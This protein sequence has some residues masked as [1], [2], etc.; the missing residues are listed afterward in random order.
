MSDTFPDLLTHF[1]QFLT[2]FEQLKR[3]AGEPKRLA[4]FYSESS[5]I[6]D[7]AEKVEE[8]AG[9]L[10]YN[11]EWFGSKRLGPVSSRFEQ[12]WEEYREQWEPAIRYGSMCSDVPDEAAE[13]RKLRPYDKYLAA[14][15]KRESAKH[16][17]PDPK[18]DEFFDPVRHD[19]ALALSLGIDH[20]RGEIHRAKVVANKCQIALDAFD[21]LRDII[22]IDIADIFRRWREAPRFLV[23]AAVHTK[24]GIEKAP[25]ND[26]LDDAIRAYVC[27][28]SLAAIAMCRAVL[29]RVVKEHYITDPT[30][31]TWTDKSGKQREKGLSELIVLAEKRFEYLGTLKLDE[32]KNAADGIL[33]RYHGRQPLSVSDENAIIDYMQK[34]KTLIQKVEG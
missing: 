25:L 2:L 29:E 3:V 8:T 27:G 30:E 21:H 1:E 19:G 33:H 28:A 16:E 4:E 9:D 7:A 31:R 13:F 5:T 34:L 14:F 6:R 15:S 20:W 23:P 12:A 11:L 18:H 32:I 10:A 24:D 26:L 17:E 22:G